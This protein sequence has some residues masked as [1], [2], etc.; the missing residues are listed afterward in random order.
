MTGELRYLYAVASARAGA[1]IAAANLRGIDGG[2]V[3]GIV[4]GRLLG[5]TSSVPASDYEEAPLNQR[6]QDLEWLAPRAASHQEVN[7]KLLELTDAVIPLAFGAIYRDADGVRR[8]HG[9]SLRV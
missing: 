8:F 6:L 7:G 2:R 5:A 3:E 4:E 1:P 9:S